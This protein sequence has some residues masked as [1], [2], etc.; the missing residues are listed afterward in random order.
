MRRRLSEYRI[1]SN[2]DDP[3]RVGKCRATACGE[4]MGSGFSEGLCGRSA[5]TAGS[6]LDKNALVF[7]LVFQIE[8]H[9]RVLLSLGLK[10][11]SP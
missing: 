5:N 8:C 4:Y 11:R 2:R 1:A 10:P 7:Q 6:A 3:S 9:G